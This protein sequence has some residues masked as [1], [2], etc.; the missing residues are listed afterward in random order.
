MLSYVVMQH[1]PERRN[2]Y[3]QDL[4]AKIQHTTRGAYPDGP[5]GYDALHVTLALGH[6]ADAGLATVACGGGG[7]LEDLVSVVDVQE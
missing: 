7:D 2:E 6:W 5:D 4:L 3:D 1:F